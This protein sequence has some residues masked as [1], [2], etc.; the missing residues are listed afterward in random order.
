MLR[1]DAAI[2]LAPTVSGMEQFDRTYTL[3]LLHR[4]R[5]GVCAHALKFGPKGRQMEE[6]AC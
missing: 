2:K 4:H 3:K 1:N 6:L 5:D